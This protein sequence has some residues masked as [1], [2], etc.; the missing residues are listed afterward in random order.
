LASN[1]PNL[2]SVALYSPLITDAGIG[3]IARCEKLEQFQL[4]GTKH[5]TDAGMQMLVQCK[6]LESV[7]LEKTR[8]L[9]DV[10]IE[11][12]AACPL[13]TLHLSGRQQ[14]FGTANALAN[15]I[16]QCPNLQSLLL[17]GA[18]RMSQAAIKAL[19][20][21]SLRSLFLSCTFAP[22]EMQQIS[23]LFSTAF[24]SLEVWGWHFPTD[25]SKR[26]CKAAGIGAKSYFG[27][28]IDTTAHTQLVEQLRLHRP[29]LDIRVHEFRLKSKKSISASEACTVA[30]IEAYAARKGILDLAVDYSEEEDDEGAD[31][32]PT[33]EAADTGKPV[34]LAAA[35]GKK[36]K[37]GKGKKKKGT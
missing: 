15:L 4:Q 26:L 35:K 3:A 9:T 30:V 18:R 7:R 22:L 8:N 1:A 31:D 25:Y 34:P 17:S 14:G 19:S 36:G 24:Q 2:L 33:T 13:R 16:Q 37:K 10:A 11:A 21:S 6:Q 12:L 32:A 23:K 28:S 29:T 20:T 5:P 27:P